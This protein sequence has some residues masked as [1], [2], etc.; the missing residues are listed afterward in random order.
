[1]RSLFML[2]ACLLSVLAHASEIKVVGSL[3][4]EDT[5]KPGEA[6]SGS[7]AIENTGK[8]SA[9]VRLYLRDYFF[10]ADGTHA[11]PPP[12]S[13]PRS[14][15]AWISFHPA[16]VSLAPGETQQV[17]WTLHA[18]ESAETK[19]SFWSVLMVQSEARSTGTS[20]QQAPHNVSIDAVHRTGVQFISHLGHATS[21]M[22][23]FVRGSLDQADGQR[24]LTL[25]L[26]NTGEA[27]HRPAVYAELYDQAGSVVGRF[28][29]GAQRIYPGC[30]ARFEIDLTELPAGQYVAYVV[31]DDAEFVFGSAVPL[32]L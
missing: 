26:S 17:R 19:G 8:A 9:D 16:N 3:V 22:L 6:Q 27:G 25:D 32:S 24:T 14:N 30:S 10:Q 1:M 2:F 21:E 18:P 20:E 12:A 28:D 4:F 11:F 5:V 15:A 31:A 23:E 13:H 7:F 29:G